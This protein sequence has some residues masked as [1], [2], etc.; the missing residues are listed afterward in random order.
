MNTPLRKECI[1][2][3]GGGNRLIAIF[4]QSDEQLG[5]FISNQIGKRKFGLNS[6]DYLERIGPN[7]RR[8]YM[9]EIFSILGGINALEQS[10]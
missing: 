3:G 2:G 4:E 10:D 5:V 9:F 8:H 6:L 1:C 7:K